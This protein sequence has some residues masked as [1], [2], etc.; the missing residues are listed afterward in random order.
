LAKKNGTSVTDSPDLKHQALLP[1]ELG[2][3]LSF[4]IIDFSIFCSEEYKTSCVE[5]SEQVEVTLR[6][7]AASPPD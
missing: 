4:A 5:T 3:T 7:R 2:Y 6:K 1:A